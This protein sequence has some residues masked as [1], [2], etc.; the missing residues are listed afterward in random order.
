VATGT[1]PGYTTT[2]AGMEPARTG[3]NW[4]AVILAILIVVALIFLIMWLF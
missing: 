1:T 4:G 3:M 2:P